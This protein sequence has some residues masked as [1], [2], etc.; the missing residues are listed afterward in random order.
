MRRVLALV[1]VGM[2]AETGRVHGREQAGHEVADRVHAEVARDEADTQ[3]PLGVWVV[4][5][6]TPA[7]TQRCF[8]VQPKFPVQVGTSSRG[9]P[10]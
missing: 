3:R 5:M 4:V 1:G 2:Q 9:R 6:V 8:K 10:G 7:G